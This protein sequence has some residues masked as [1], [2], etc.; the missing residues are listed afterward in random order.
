MM[1]LCIRNP[2]RPV[3]LPRSARIWIGELTRE[4][5]QAHIDGFDISDEQYPPENWYGP[6]VSLSKL[7]IFKPLPEEL[8]RKYDVVHLRFFM[9][10]ASD[11]N[12]HI[13]VNN[14]KAMLSE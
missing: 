7:D 6:N 1:R 13:V 14:L 2:S 11:D 12:V 5:P 3:C 4:L 8:K 10:I 9:T